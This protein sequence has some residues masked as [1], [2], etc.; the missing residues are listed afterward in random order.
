MFNIAVLWKL[1]LVFVTMLLTKAM[2][3]ILGRRRSYYADV[4]KYLEKK[5]AKRLEESQGKK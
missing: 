1:E 4:E 2:F 3:Q 5:A